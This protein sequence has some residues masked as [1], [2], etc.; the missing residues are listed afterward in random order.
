MGGG[1]WPCLALHT[2]AFVGENRGHF[3]KVHS[4]VVQCNVGVTKSP[5]FKWAYP[6]KRGI[7]ENC[8]L[9]KKKIFSSFFVFV[10]IVCSNYKPLKTF[11]IFC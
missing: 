11:T 1:T 9:K 6:F 10:N 8:R 3:C 2:L 7:W 5:V 4:I